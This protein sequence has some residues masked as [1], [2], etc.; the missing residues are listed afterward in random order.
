MTS[1]VEY[2]RDQAALTGSVDFGAEEGSNIKGS[3][4]LKVWKNLHVGGSVHY[5][6]GKNSDVKNVQAG[7][8]WNTDEFDVSVSGTVKKTKD[9]DAT[10][11][12][13][14]YFHKVNS[15]LSV[16]TEVVLDPNSA[17]SKKDT[18]M[19]FGTQ[20]KVDDNSTFKAKCDVSGKFGLSFTQKYNPNIS[21]TVA[22]NVD[23][24]HFSNK[25]T[26]QFGF[27]LNFE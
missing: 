26:S 23:T 20:Y 25:N 15:N 12:G 8:A 16:G 3:I 19:T 17:A 9:G 4:N 1:A 11:I 7:V 5:L 14:G 18:K 27:A 24:N 6:Q 13:V 10:E 21:W 22:A 2:T